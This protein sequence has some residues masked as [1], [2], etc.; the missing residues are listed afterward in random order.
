MPPLV[1]KRKMRASTRKSTAKK[2]TVK[3]MAKR[4]YKRKGYT[5]KRSYTKKRYTRKRGLPGPTGKTHGR[6]S[7]MLNFNRSYNREHG[8]LKSFTPGQIASVSVSTGVP[9]TQ[10]YILVANTLDAATMQQY[11]PAGMTIRSADGVVEQVWSNFYS[12]NVMY[13]KLGVK[14]T[15]ADQNTDYGPVRVCLTPLRFSDYVVC[16]TSAPSV[17][18]CKWVGATPTAAF[19]NQ[20]EHNRTRQCKMMNGAASS[21]IMNN[22]FISNSVRPGFVYTEPM[23]EAASNASGNLVFAESQGVGIGAS[24]QVLWILTLFFERPTATGT[25]VFTFDFYNT[26]RMKAWDPVPAFLITENKERR[27]DAIPPPVKPPH[28]RVDEP[29]AC[30]DECAGFRDLRVQTPVPPLYLPI[31]TPSRSSAKR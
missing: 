13:S 8:M 12:A 24:G 10:S 15:R 31:S 23:W 20:T 29:E 30:Q 17:A 7:T 22:T 9:L 14:I 25:A 3:R 19:A 2:T 16:L 11:L 5:K 6:Y 27:A 1:R 21:G 18:G 26:M 28:V 4:V